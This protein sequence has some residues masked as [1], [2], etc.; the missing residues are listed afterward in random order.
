MSIEFLEELIED[1]KYYIPS[2]VER[3][4]LKEAILEEIE[5]GA[6]CNY[7]EEGFFDYLNKSLPK[8]YNNISSLNPV[9]QEDK[10]EQIMWKH[11][12]NVMMITAYDAPKRILD[13]PAGLIKMG[14]LAIKIVKSMLTHDYVN[15]A[16][17]VIEWGH[18]EYKELKTIDD[19]NYEVSK[20]L[21]KNHQKT[22]SE[23]KKI[24]LYG[25]Y[26]NF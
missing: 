5:E 8:L 4:L 19:L 11:H 13:V 17:D 26:D 23:L 7:Y 10:K 12:I 22:V 18:E 16:K 20:L 21:N 1:S 9:T 24:G 14:S 15:V 2:K 6:D 25:N 3:L